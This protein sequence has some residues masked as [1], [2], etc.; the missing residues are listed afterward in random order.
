MVNDQMV[1]D[2]IP[3]PFETSDLESGEV[4]VPYGEGILYIVD[5]SGKL[6]RIVEGSFDSYQLPITNHQ[7]PIGIYFIKAY[8]NGQWYTRKILVH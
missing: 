6:I 1:N 8:I 3:N 2:F 4:T 5:I 7:L